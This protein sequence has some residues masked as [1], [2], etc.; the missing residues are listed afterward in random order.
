MRDVEFSPAVEAQHHRLDRS[1]YQNIFVIGDV[2]GCRGT[3]ERLISAIDPSPDDLLVLVGDLVRR[4]PDSRGVIELVRSSPNIRSVRGNNEEKIILGRKRVPDL[5]VK[6]IRWLRTL[7]VA[8]SWPG[9]L[10]IH[11]GFDPWKPLEN[12]TVHD[13]QNIASIADD[14]ADRPYWWEVYTGRV[15]VFFGHKVLERPLVGDSAIGLDTGCC[16]GGQLSAFDCSTGR[17]ITEKAPETY[18]DRPPRKVISP[19]TQATMT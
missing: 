13:L 7:P 2:H 18:K 14:G 16:Y 15:R 10:V 11:G 6:D 3:L 12:H 9:N 5:T 19:T 4:G 17:V 1:D 8:I